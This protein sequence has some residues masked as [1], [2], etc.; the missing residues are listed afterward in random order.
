ME[1]DHDSV[2]RD[3]VQDIGVNT[4]GAELIGDSYTTQENTL[5]KKHLINLE[6]DITSG[7]HHTEHSN[8]SEDTTHGKKNTD[9]N[10]QNNTAVI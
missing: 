2:T 4:A 10:T 7:K 5:H 1:R 3:T 6:D 9:R 8:Y